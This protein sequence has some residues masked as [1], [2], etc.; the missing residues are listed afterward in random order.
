MSDEQACCVFNREWGF[1]D[2]KK[3]LR[4]DFRK[5]CHIFG[6]VIVPSSQIKTMSCVSQ[7][8]YSFYN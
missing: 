8:V 5:H 4:F 7:K 1:A 3:E 6:F 2:S